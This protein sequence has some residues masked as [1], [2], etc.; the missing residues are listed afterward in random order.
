MASDSAVAVSGSVEA[1]SPLKLTN[2]VEFGLSASLFSRDLNA[3]MA[4]AERVDAGMIRINGETAGVEP[5]AP[6]GGMKGSSSWSR[7][8]GLAARDFY[9]QI[10]PISIDRAG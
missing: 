8:Q 9:T 3:A 6:F 4:F 10:K 5:Q 1:S 2:S 7:E